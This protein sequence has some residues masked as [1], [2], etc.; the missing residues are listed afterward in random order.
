MSVDLIHV[1][2]CDRTVPGAPLLRNLPFTPRTPN[3]ERVY[4]IALPCTE[5]ANGR[6]WDA[7]IRLAEQDTGDAGA[8]DATSGEAGQE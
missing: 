8:H 3:W 7:A 5:A 1:G 4:V 6:G 2:W